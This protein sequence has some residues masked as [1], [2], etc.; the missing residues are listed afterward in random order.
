[1]TPNQPLASLAAADVLT[2]F[3]KRARMNQQEFAA[4]A[5]MSITSLQ[6][7]LKGNAPIT[8]TDLV[9]L[10]RA[11]ELDPVEVMDEVM[12]ALAKMEK[13]AQDAVSEVPASLEAHRKKKVSEMSIEEIESQQRKAAINDAELD[14]PEP[15]AP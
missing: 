15:E 10:S 2:G 3:Y 6:K 9:E 12:K 13:A 14:E 7:K 5:S 11:L 1:M 8:A 4:A